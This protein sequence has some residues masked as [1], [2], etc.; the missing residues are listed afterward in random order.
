MRNTVKLLGA[1]GL[2]ALSL[3][4]AAPAL[5]AGTAAGTSVGNTATVN[6]TVGSV[7]QTAQTASNSFVVDNKIVLTATFQPSAAVSVS[8]GQ[9]GAVLT[10]L[11][12]NSSNTTIDVALNAA[13]QSSGSLVFGGTNNVT[14]TT[15][16]YATNTPSAGVC[17]YSG[18]TVVTY[19]DQVAA[20]GAKC[21]YVLANIPAG[22]TNG[23]N[24]GV[25][26][27]VTA[28]SA[29]TPGTL[30]ATLIASTGAWTPGTAQTVLADAAGN[31]NGNAS[32]I[33][34]VAYDGKYTAL[35]QFIISA[36]VLSVY[37]NVQVIS[38]PV[39]GSTNPKAIPGAKLQYCIIVYNAASATASASGISIT[40][41][42]PS[43]LTYVPS[44]IFLGATT[45]D[46][47]TNIVASSATVTG[48]TCTGGT[49]GGSYSAPAVTGSDASAL[50]AGGT[51]AMSFQATIN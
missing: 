29:S 11:V 49:A 8:P 30:G 21:V 1:A 25:D 20:D 15:F 42:L 12:T 38:D 6:F 4:I 7:A 18:T 10:Y 9:T 41:P 37:K 24:G 14:A 40:D 33:T 22:A 3:A 50:A 28:A 36:P 48:T 17:T 27:Q 31:G 51:W 34:D 47:G 23:Q 39:N 46:T 2:S 16:T 26:L 32:G 13:A 45:S 43:N 5:A 44:T 19:L 35:G